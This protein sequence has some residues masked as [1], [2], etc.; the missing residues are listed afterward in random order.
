MMTT[1][2]VIE[3]SLADLGNV[4]QSYRH[5][6]RVVTPQAPIVLPD[7]IFKWYHVH[8][9]GVPVLETMDA[10]ARAVIAGAMANTAWDP[11]YGLNFAMLH[12]STAGAFLIAGV[13]RGH[14]ELWERL[15]GKDLATNSP[16]E[17]I[18]AGEDGPV[19]CVWEMAVT[20]HERMA[21]HRYLFTERSEADKRTWLADLYSG[22]A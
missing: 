11:S 1:A 15:Y 16:F 18:V 20:C 22:Q 14:Q 4:P 3:R 17:R 19:G 5:E 13:W 7:T 2:T 6:W 9:E 10:E 12:V 8:R 21:W